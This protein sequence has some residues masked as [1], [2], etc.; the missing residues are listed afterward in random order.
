[1]TGPPAPTP[2]RADLLALT[3]E[4]LAALSNRGLVKRAIR[5]VEAG[6]APSIGIDANGTVLGAHPDGAASTLPPGAGLGSCT[7]GAAAV[8][9]HLLATVLAYQ[10]TAAA[11]VAPA[12][13]TT[14]WSP[15]EFTDEALA[16][17]V[18]ARALGS[19]RRAYRAGYVA[20]VRRPTPSRPEPSVELSSCT[21]RFLVPH[22][23]GYARA[24]AADGSRPDAI[25]LAVWAFRAAD[26]A[27]PVGTL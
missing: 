18:G 22:E 16:A 6:A 15:G 27:D 17:L 4:A 20:R 8:C 11:P 24:D 25:P 26:S 3:T 13:S 7:C 5:E 9:R 23:L 12:A 21:V 2:V 10:A 19:A 14:V 1:M